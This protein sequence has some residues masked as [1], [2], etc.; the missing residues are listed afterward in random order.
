[1]EKKFKGD[2]L[3]CFYLKL[4]ELISLESMILRSS[5]GQAKGLKVKHII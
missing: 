2:S 1:M 4:L 3:S 5:Q